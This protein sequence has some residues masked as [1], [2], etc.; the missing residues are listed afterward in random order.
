MK[1][2]PF[3]EVNKKIKGNLFSVLNP[4]DTHLLQLDESKLSQIIDIVRDL[5]K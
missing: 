3:K 1:K 4:N 5:W 2:E